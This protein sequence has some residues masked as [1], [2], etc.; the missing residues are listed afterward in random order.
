MQPS[1]TTPGEDA[2]DEMH[3]AD[4]RL[5]WSEKTTAKTLALANGALWHHYGKNISFLI[6]VVLNLMNTIFATLLPLN[7]NVAEG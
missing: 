5:S 2:W 3:Q 7:S 6:Y 1:V 4:G